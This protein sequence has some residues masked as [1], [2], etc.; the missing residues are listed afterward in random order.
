[1]TFVHLTRYASQPFVQVA[2]ALVKSLLDLSLDTRVPVVNGL[3]FSPV[4]EGDVTARGGKLARSAVSMAAMREGKKKSYTGE[5]V[6]T[7]HVFHIRHKPKLYLRS[8]LQRK[9]P[10]LYPRFLAFGR[11]RLLK[12]RSCSDRSK[13]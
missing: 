10:L 9:G 3:C 8:R 4:A 6:W 12:M 7:W 11:T 5:R 2:A 13:Q 1:M